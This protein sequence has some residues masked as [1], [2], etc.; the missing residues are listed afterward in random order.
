F[1]NLLD[2]PI[3]Y[4]PWLTTLARLKPGIHS[5][6][7]TA[8]LEALWL[9]ALPQGMKAGNFQVPRLVFSSASTG[10]SNLRRQFSQPLFVLMAVVGIVLLIACANIANLLLARAAARRSEFAMRIALGA[11]RWRM[12]RQLLAEGIVLGIFGGLCGILLAR[13]AMRLLVVYMSA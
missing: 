10:I 8:V 6:Q 9:E 4:R 3:I 7:A 2:N 13:W 12:I 1:E 11:G 5:L